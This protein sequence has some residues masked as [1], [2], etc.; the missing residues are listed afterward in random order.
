ME[1]EKPSEGIL[2]KSKIPSLAVKQDKLA[3]PP[4]LSGLLSIGQGQSAVLSWPID[5]E[6]NQTGCS[7]MVRSVVVWCGCMA[8]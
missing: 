4:H 2:L 1:Q 6:A 5:Q 3:D 8:R 7:C